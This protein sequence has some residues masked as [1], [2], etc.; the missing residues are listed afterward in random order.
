MRLSQIHRECEPSLPESYWRVRLWPRQDG[1]GGKDSITR[2][3][4]G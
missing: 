2:V 1:K 4:V 3:V